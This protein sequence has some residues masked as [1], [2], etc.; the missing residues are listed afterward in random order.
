MVD[1]YAR[2]GCE[3]LIDTATVSELADAPVPTSSAVRR[4][5]TMG[6]V[7][8]DVSWA[9]DHAGHAF[10]SADQYHRPHRKVPVFLAASKI[11][12]RAWQVAEIE[13]DL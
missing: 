4:A 2:S 10:P 3:R 6:R 11:D 8:A 12:W 9:A 5:P 7:E 13:S 1:W